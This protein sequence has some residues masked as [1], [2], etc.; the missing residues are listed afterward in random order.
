MLGSKKPL[1]KVCHDRSL[2]TRVI[3]IL[4]R[5]VLH[6]DGV[7]YFIELYAEAKGFM[8]LQSKQGYGG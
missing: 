6:L 3:L 8:F 7:L 5:V 2:E 4:L 1:Y